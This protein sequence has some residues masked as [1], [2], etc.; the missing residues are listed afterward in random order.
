MKA[1]LAQRLFVMFSTQDFLLNLKK[2]GFET[3]DS[4]IDE[5][6]DSIVDQ[7]QRYSAAYAAVQYVAKQNHKTLLQKIQPVL[8]HNQNRL[9]KYYQESNLGVQQFL[10]QHIPDQHWSL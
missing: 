9:S 3:F 4:V 10:Q 8:D 7:W 6:Y 5:S 2:L 1:L